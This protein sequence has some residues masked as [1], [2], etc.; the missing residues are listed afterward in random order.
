MCLPE[1]CGFSRYHYL[2]SNG[3]LRSSITNKATYAD[4]KQS[5]TWC[6]ER[7]RY[8]LDLISYEYVFFTLIH[9]LVTLWRNMCEVKA[10]T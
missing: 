1:E 4:N 5:T 2:V 10:L 9:L 7:S 3:I 8:L 6:R